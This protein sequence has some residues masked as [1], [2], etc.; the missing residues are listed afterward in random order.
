MAVVAA[1][2]AVAATA[3]SDARP[4]RPRPARL[5]SAIS[6]PRIGLLPPQRLALPRPGVPAAPFALA[7]D[8]GGAPARLELEPHS[9]RAADFTVMVQVEGGALVEVPPPPVTT[10]KGSV[11]GRP[12]SKVRASLHDGKLTAYVELSRGDVWVVQPASDFDGV[13][14][15]P[16][17]HVSFRPSSVAPRTGPGCGA[18]HIA[19]P[20][21]PGPPEE[22]GAFALGGTGNE[23]TEIGIDADVLFYQE[24]GSSVPN[25][26]A[27]VENV[28]NTVEF[29][30]ERDTGITYEITF[31]VVRTSIPDNPY[32]EDESGALLCQ[33][34]TKWNVAPES[35]VRRDVAHLFTGRSMFDA[36]GVAYNSTIC[37]I[38]GTTVGCPGSGNLA[39]GLGESRFAGATFDERVALHAHE[40]GHNWSALHCTGPDCHIMCAVINECG[41]VAGPNLDFGPISEPPII[42]FKNTRTCLVDEPSPLS[43]PFFDDIPGANLD[44]TKWI[45]SQSASSNP[46]QADAPSPPNVMRLVSLNAAD[47]RDGEIRSNVM[48]LGDES[49]VTLSYWLKHAGVEAGEAIWTEFWTSSHTWSDINYFQSGGVDLPFFIQFTHRL[50]ASALHDEFRLRFRVECDETNDQW[51][52]DDIEIAG[53]GTPCPPDLDGNGD[54]GFGDLLLTLSSWGPCPGCPEDLDADGSVG[55]TDLLQVLSGWG[56]CP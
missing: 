7:V 18:D 55:F 30:Y 43:L 56:P 49:D 27:D 12:G 36:I 52:I 21:L 19:Q 8:L 48:L 4:V 53:A 2:A 46:S 10:Y 34:R 5:A 39:Y 28:M 37:N 35:A 3:T 45:W 32:T 33:F 38:T 47:Y 20:D 13:V 14:A 29:V 44:P 24:N 41:G 11:E 25:T 54:V 31:I 51:F 16:G 6:V 17:T 40:L 1:A 15:P 22:G 23:I 42:A 26:I 50:P 9:I